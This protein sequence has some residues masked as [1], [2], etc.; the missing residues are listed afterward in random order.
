MIAVRLK[1]II[2][3]VIF[4]ALYFFMGYQAFYKKSGSAE[5]IASIALYPFLKFQY[6]IISTIDRCKNFWSKHDSLLEKIA[7]LQEDNSALQSE[8]I[9]LQASKNFVEN[10]HELITFKKRYEVQKSILAH[11]ILKQFSDA[12]HSLL[13]DRGSQHGCEVDMV[14]VYKS[15]LLGRVECVYPFYS[16]IR[17]ITDKC[18]KVAAYCRS[19]KA[20]GIHEGCNSSYSSLQFVSHLSQVTPHD[21]LISSGEGLLFP[22]G[23]GIGRIDSFQQQGLYYAISVKPLLKFEELEYCYL[24]KKGQEL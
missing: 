9:Q 4:V 11:V 7:L 3:I 19:S 17:L 12:E 6:S 16:K 23:F 21:I 14:A 10:T 2:G 13:V 20:R 1:I 8:I 22:Q 15:C 24:I 5:R 18:C